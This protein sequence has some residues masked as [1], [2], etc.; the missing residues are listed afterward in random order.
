[1]G[2]QKTEQIW[3]CCPSW[4]SVLD[5]K[6]QENFTNLGNGLEN[7]LMGIFLC[8]VCPLYTNNISGKGLGRKSLVK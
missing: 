4:Y 5:I 6:T 2:S 1:M 8:Q 7:R 3:T